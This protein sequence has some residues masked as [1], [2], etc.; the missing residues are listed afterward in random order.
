MSEREEREKYARLWLVVRHA[1]RRTAARC[2]AAADV[3][4]LIGEV[5]LHLIE[6]R[7]I[8]GADPARGKLES[9]L[10]VAARNRTL[11]L[12]RK[13]QPLPWQLVP[14]DDEHIELRLDGPD[15][16]LLRLA[17]RDLLRVSSRLSAPDH[18]VIFLSLLHDLT[19]AEIL[20]VLGEEVTEKAINTMQRRLQRLKDRLGELLEEA[21][22][23]PGSGGRNEEEGAK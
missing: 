13:K 4:D 10:Y 18:E 16:V 6:N 5:W 19:A 11:S 9:L 2:R 23:T 20:G 7:V 22:S 14:A 15:P 1:V 12:L 8:E 3:D 21:T 17:H